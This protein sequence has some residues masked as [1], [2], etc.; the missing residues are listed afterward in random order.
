MRPLVLALAALLLGG[1]T[2]NLRQVQEPGRAVAFPT[3]NPWTSMV[4]AARADDGRVLVVDL[5]W[6]GAGKALVKRLRSLDASPADVT[7]VFLTH[8]HRDHIGAWRTVRH[9]RFHLSTAEVPY[10]TGERAYADLPS[11]LAGEVAGEAGP[12]PGEVAVH[13]FASDTA[14]AFGA[15][16]LRAFLAPGHTPGHAAYLFR[17][18]LF[19]GDAIARKPLTG[20]GGADPVFTTDRAR[21][22]E[23]LRSLFAR[24]APFSPRWVCNAHA[25][26]AR[27]DSAFVRRVTR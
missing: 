8:G 6:R 15:D 11:R 23:S 5:G 2:Y 19:A 25:K 18:V 10:F 13:P 24:A 7:D 9:A 14:F 27:L 22:R 3:S 17:G 4:Y 20:F 16:T 1:C 26:C 21:A 12:W